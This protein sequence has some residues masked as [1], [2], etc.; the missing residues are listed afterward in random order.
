MIQKELGDILGVN[1][2]TISGW[3]NANDPIPFTKLINFAIFI[4]FL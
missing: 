4:T 2:K 1:R 3:E